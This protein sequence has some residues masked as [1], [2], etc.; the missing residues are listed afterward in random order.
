MARRMVL[1]GFPGG[2]EDVQ[3]LQNLVARLPRRRLVLAGL[4]LVRALERQQRAHE[5]DDRVDVARFL[6][7]V[8]L[9]LELRDFRARLFISSSETPMSPSA[10]DGRATL[11]RR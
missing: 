8:H 2:S 1:D 7:F 10:L 4:A 11:F 6:C 3:T 9:L 5:F